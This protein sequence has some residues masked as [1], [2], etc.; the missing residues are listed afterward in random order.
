MYSNH[1]C[2]KGPVS[3]YSSW[4]WTTSFGFVCIIHLLISPVNQ[5]ITSSPRMDDC[6]QRLEKVYIFIALHALQGYLLDSIMTNKSR[7]LMKW[8]HCICQGGVTLKNIFFNRKS[9]TWTKYW[10][11][12]VPL[13]LQRMSTQSI[14]LYFLQTGQKCDHFCKQVMC[15]EVSSKNFLKLSGHS[16]NVYTMKIKWIGSTLR[17]R[18]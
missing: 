16:I 11:L 13:P 17:L 12:V 9:N 3:L 10:C 18:I 6:I 5:T 8:S 1:L 14:L 15:T 7:T 2:W 4:E